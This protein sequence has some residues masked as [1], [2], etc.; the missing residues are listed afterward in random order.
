LV[1]G[2]L[3]ACESLG[4]SGSGG[5]GGDSGERDFIAYGA[6]I[7][8]AADD[9]RR[10][11]YLFAVREHETSPTAG[12]AIRLAIAS[13]G[14]E[15]FSPSQE[16][17]SLLAFAESSAAN[18]DVLVFLGF[19][20]PFVEQLVEQRATIENESAARQTLEAQLEALKELE[21]QLDGPGI[22]R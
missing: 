1:F 17:L 15:N 3:T 9:E 14:V 18:E 11:I 5:G 16:I 19:F 2:L 10:V 7:Q 20:R 21:T 13:L 6:G 4:L 22:G 8:A 12:S